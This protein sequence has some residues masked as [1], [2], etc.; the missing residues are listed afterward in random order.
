[1]KRNVT[2]EVGE[3]TGAKGGAKVVI[4][5]EGEHGGTFVS[6]DYSTLDDLK[7]EVQEIKE[8]LDRIVE[9]S[10]C[11]FRSESADKVGKKTEFKLAQDPEENWKRLQA[12]TSD[13][14]FFHAF[15]KL[16][17]GVRREI[18][19]HVLSK[20]NIFKGRASVFSLHFD[21][22]SAVLVE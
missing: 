11:F 16:K 7:S 2:I 21:E 10:R 20:E 5:L 19:E 22:D 17:E 12:L 14:D 18:A 13:E 3:G 8:R 1:M 9:E 4:R 15:N 6:M